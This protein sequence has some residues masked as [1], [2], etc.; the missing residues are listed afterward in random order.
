[1]PVNLTVAQMFKIQG[2]LFQ[3]F[4]GPRYWV[5]SPSGGPED[6]GFRVGLT[7]LFPK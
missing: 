3:V 5:D 2:Q 6:L 1:M 7:L 4:A